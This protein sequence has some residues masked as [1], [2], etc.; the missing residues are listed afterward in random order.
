MLDRLGDRCSVQTM[1]SRETA[2][3]ADSGAN[4]ALQI[5]DKP[6]TEQR[7]LSGRRLSRYWLANLIVARIR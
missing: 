1:I 2:S 5:I 3:V 4:D 6:L 7:I